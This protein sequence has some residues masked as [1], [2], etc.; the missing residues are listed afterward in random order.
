MGPVHLRVRDIDAARDFYGGMLGM[1]VIAS[2]GDELTLG[3]DVPLVRITGDAD[4]PLRPLRATGLYH[5]AILLPERRYLGRILE[6]F[7]AFRQALDGAADHLVS[8]ALYLSDPEGNGIEIYVDR[9]RATWQ[10]ADGNLQ[11]ASKVIDIH[12]ILSEAG[13]EGWNGVP[14]STVVGHVHLQVAD[15]PSTE[16]FYRD[17]LGFDI[18]TRYG[19]QATFLAAG[20][21]H[22]HLGANTWGSHNAPPP[23]ARSTGLVEYTI[24]VRQA[25]D[26]LRQRLDAEEHPDGRGLLLVDPSGNRV[27]VVA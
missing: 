23:P 2:R 24:H 4:A 18:T 22:H 1:R 9:P 25:L 5:V 6:H 17:L 3:A 10:W 21:Y 14:H 16:V 20:G 13:D 15:I 7:S 12:S 26:A 8:E 11:M 19:D 27:R